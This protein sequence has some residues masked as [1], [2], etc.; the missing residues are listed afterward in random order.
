MHLV[1]DSSDSEEETKRKKSKRALKDDEFEE[2]PIDQRTSRVR[3]SSYT[4]LFSF[5]AAMKRV[6]LD[7]EGLA[8]GHVMAQSKKNREQLVD[9]SY[10]R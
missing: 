6:Y 3:S 4:L 5:R 7:A 8:L 10:N 9:H 1:D 2:V